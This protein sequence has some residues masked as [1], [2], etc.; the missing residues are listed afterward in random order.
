MLAKP[1]GRVEGGG[2]ETSRG[3]TRDS[4]RV[5]LASR[6]SP[7]RLDSVDANHVRS[8]NDILPGIPALHRRWH[9]RT[10]ARPPVLADRL[11]RVGAIARAMTV[12]P[13]AAAIRE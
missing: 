12:Q 7:A 5:P 6:P 9:H 8:V 10:T 11:C 2:V 4:E 13:S 3:A 1:H